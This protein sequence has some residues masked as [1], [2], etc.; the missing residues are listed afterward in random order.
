MDFPDFIGPNGLIYDS[1]TSQF[2][3]VVTLNL[4]S[5]VLQPLL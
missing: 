1:E 5:S 4:S 2:A 3:L